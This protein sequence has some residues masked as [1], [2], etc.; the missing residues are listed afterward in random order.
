MFKEAADMRA[1]EPLFPIETQGDAND[2]IGRVLVIAC[3]ALA[4]EIIAIRK[5]NKLDHVDLTCLPAQLHNTPD[6]IPDEVRRTILMNNDVYSDILVAYGDCGT[7]G[8][9]DRALEETGARRIEGA[10]CYAFFSGLD[11][12][13]RMEEDQLGTFYLTD[14]L[15]RHFQTMVIEPLGLDWHPHLRDMYFGHYTRVLYIAQTDD[16]A[17]ED[18][19]RRAAERLG[20]AFEMKRTGYGLLTPFL[21]KDATD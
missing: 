21:D 6:K 4:R 15:A 2:K 13:D 8:L 14:F 10:H 12:F 1:G 19:A 17:L 7:G 3:G 20:L 9:L 5:A 18:A 16:P 11:E